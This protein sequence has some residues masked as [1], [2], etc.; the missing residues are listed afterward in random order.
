M[1]VSEWRVHA[2]LLTGFF[3]TIRFRRSVSVVGRAISLFPMRHYVRLPR[4]GAHYSAVPPMGKKEG[5][6]R[7]N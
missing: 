6:K 1:K 2:G 3:S 4:A 5:L 7:S